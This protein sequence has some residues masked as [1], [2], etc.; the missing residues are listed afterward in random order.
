MKI[1]DANTHI[2]KEPLSIRLKEL[3]KWYGE[4]DEGTITHYATAQDILSGMRKNSIEKSLVMPNTVTTDKNDAKKA[5][6]MVAREIVG[7]PDLLGVACVHP[8][9]KTVI[10][11]LEEGILE[12]GLRLL[13]LSPD[14]QGFELNDEAVWTL[15]ERVEEMDLSVILYTQWAKNIETYFDAQ[16]LYDIGSS[17]H[18]NF[19]LPHMGINSDLSSLSETVHLENIFFETSHSSPKEI[20]RALEMF[21]SERLVF[22][23]D[24]S[25]N[26]YP[27]YELEKIT[28][29]EINKSDKEK[30]L[31]KNLEKLLK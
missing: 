26:L 13:M 17:F 22:G 30:I 16:I 12:N 25:Y 11:D 15:F 29:L 21:G 7:Y 5:S 18:I 8:Y 10:Y 2:E 20:L 31:G 9:S 27:K 3:N 19:I 24:F 28:S 1:F 14:R 6:E 23:S 4:V